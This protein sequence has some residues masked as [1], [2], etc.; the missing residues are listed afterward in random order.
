MFSYVGM[1]IA[2]I[3]EKSKDPAS[4]AICIFLKLKILNFNK[5]HYCIIFVINNQYVAANRIAKS[6]VDF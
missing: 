6:G 5:I 4:A 3:A 1:E 2:I